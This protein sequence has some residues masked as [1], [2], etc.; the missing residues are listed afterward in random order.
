MITEV[1]YERLYNLGNFENAKYGATSTVLDGNAL[2]AFI[3][4]RAAVEAQH[5]Q[6][7]TERVAEQQRQRAK[8]DR[9]ADEDLPL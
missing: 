4:A 6:F 9:Q 7:L 2:A 5:N 1:R 8:W 3:E